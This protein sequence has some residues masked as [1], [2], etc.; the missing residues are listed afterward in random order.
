MDRG[1]FER[2]VRRGCV[3]TSLYNV[4]FMLNSARQNQI[5]H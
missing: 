4:E 1:Y 3:T 2:V 5:A